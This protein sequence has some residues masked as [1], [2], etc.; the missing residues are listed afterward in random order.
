MANVAVV[1]HS[2]YGH[3]KRMAEYV[4]KGAGADLIE[5]DAEGN[6]TEAQWAT[7]DAAKAIVFGSPTYMGM[8][9]WQFKKFAD[10]TSKRWFTMAWKDKLFGGFT[11]S[12]SLNGDKGSTM[13][14]FV[15][16]AMQHGGLWAGVGI[17]PA[18]TSAAT[19]QD[20]NNI[21]SAMGAMAISPSDKGADAMSDGDLETARLYGE[22]IAKLSAK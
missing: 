14:Y 12:A 10:A 22:R 18:N 6:I 17:P 19:R 7:L 2:G 15:T 3:T 5:V 16:L 8:V 4:A 9:S 11:N 13:H 1:F 21:G 20:V